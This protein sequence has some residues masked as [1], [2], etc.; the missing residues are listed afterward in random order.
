MTTDK[1]SARTILILGGYGNTGILIAELLLRHTN[2]RVILAGR[3]IHKAQ[4]AAYRLGVRI[5]KDHLSA[6]YADAQKPKSLNNAFRDIDTVVVASST[7]EY[8]KNIAQ[9]CL[10]NGTDYMDLQ[11]S[12]D[13]IRFL[14]SIQDQIKSKGSVF[15]TDGGFHPGLPSVLIRY[16]SSIFNRIENA[17][18]GSVIK[19]DWKRISLSDTTLNEFTRELMNLEP[20]CFAGGAW[21]HTKLRD[22]KRFHFGEPFGKIYCM[23]MLLEEIR[24]IPDNI[25]SLRETGFFVSGFNWFVDYITMPV[26]FVLLKAMPKTAAIPSARLMEWGLK[27][28]SRG[29]F[30]TVLLL[31]S[32]G[33]KDDRQT[34]LRIKISHEDGYFL[35]ASAVVASLMQHL[36]GT[37]N[38]PGLYLQATAVDPKRMLDDLQRLGVN[39]EISEP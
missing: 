6:R 21:T 25:P 22:Y 36:D 18:V 28:F 3:D 12:S 31:D 10:I 1:G 26:I 35:T 34:N 24:E 20:I 16:A 30:G 38:K 11:Y 39:V 23:P 33:R 8:T 13:K 27:T 7:V 14:R 5:G 15:I 4:N 9:A 2:T 17:N 29:P 32:N 37:L 19:I